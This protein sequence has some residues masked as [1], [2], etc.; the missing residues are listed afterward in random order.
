MQS[1]SPRMWSKDEVQEQ[2]ALVNSKILLTQQ[3]ASGWRS[4]ARAR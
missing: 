1:T 3:Q 4:T 2:E